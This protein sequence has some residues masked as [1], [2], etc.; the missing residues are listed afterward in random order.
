MGIRQRHLNSSEQSWN[1]FVPFQIQFEFSGYLC[2]EVRQ[3]VKLICIHGVSSSDTERLPSNVIGY[4]QRSSEGNSK[5][6]QHFE[7]SSLNQWVTLSS[8]AEDQI[9][10]TLKVRTESNT[11]IEPPVVCILFTPQDVISSF[12]LAEVHLHRDTLKS[13]SFTSSLTDFKGPK[14]SGKSEE[15]VAVL[16]Q[17][18]STVS[19]VSPVSVKTFHELPKSAVSSKCFHLLPWLLLSFLNFCGCLVENCTQRLHPLVLYVLSRPSTCQHLIE[20]YKHCWTVGSHIRR[21]RY[22]HFLIYN[23]YCQQL[24]DTALGIGICV[25]IVYFELPETLAGNVIGWADDVALKLGQLVKALMG[26]PAGLKLNAHLTKTMGLFFQYHIFLWTGYLTVLRS[27]MPTLIWYSSWVGVLGA[28]CQL[29]L[30]SDMLSTLTLHIYCFYVYAARMFHLQMYALGSFW[31]LFRGKKWNALRSRV[32]S[33]TYNTDQLFVGTLLFT[34]LLFL[35]P[36]TA[37]YYAVFTVLRILVLIAQ[38][39]L[40]RLVSIALHTPV[41][42]LLV[43]LF[44]PKHVAGSV[45]FNVHHVP[46]D[47]DCLVLTMQTSQLPGKDLVSLSFPKTRTEQVPKHT[48]AEFLSNLATGKLVYPWVER[49]SSD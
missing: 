44:S 8:N 34:V 30:V 11:T 46:K 33:A 32:D 26:A 23:A 9:V 13:S 19:N 16:S 17:C 39:I 42:T 10:C 1:I 3:S 47:K 20:R 49:A 43:R 48:W 35:L 25:F 37:L 18:L 36:T 21:S 14:E 29:C 22:Q 38:G 40:I 6:V 27:V 2:G 45:V 7:S 15:T 31:R 12:V 41:F 28:S 24:L 5:S 4:W